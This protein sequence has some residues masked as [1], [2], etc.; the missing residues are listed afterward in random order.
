MIKTQIEISI[1][2]AIKINK[3][4][5]HKYCDIIFNTY[6]QTKGMI[7][8]ILTSD[9]ELS[10]LKI[11]FFGDDSFTDVIAFNLEEINEPIEGEIYISWDRIIDN[12]KTYNNS[13]SDELD[14]VVIHGILHL[15]GFNDKTKKDKIKM[16][17]LENKFLDIFSNS[18]LEL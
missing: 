1:N 12:S 13:I 10:K 8:F 5:L 2:E 3:N 7:T 18:I 11:E 14:R 6:N 15:L 4:S 16:T 9:I 17:D